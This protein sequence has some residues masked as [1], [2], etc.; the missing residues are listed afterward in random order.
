MEG[1]DGGVEEDVG[2]LLVVLDVSPSGYRMRKR[3]MRTKQRELPNFHFF[4]DI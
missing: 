1:C 2:C 4:F 3:R